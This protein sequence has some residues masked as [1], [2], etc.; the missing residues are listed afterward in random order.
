MKTCI[1]TILLLSFIS[2]HTLAQSS[3]AKNIDSILTVGKRHIESQQYREAAVLYLN[4]SQ[5]L[6]LNEVEHIEDLCLNGIDAMKFIDDQYLTRML[7]LRLAES[8]LYATQ[9]SKVLELEKKILSLDIELLT[10]DFYGAAAYYQKELLTQHGKDKRA[11]ELEEEH[12][13]ITNE[14]QEIKTAAPT[15]GLPQGVFKYDRYTRDNKKLSSTITI[16]GSTIIKES[17]LDELDI[18]YNS[19]PNF[20]YKVQSSV[21]ISDNNY[22]LCVTSL[23]YSGDESWYFLILQE[24]NDGLVISNQINFEFDY[25]EIDEENHVQQMYTILKPEYEN[26]LSEHINARSEIHYPD[27]RYDSLINLPVIPLDKVSEIK[28]EFLNKLDQRDDLNS[29]L[30]EDA[31]TEDNWFHYFLIDYYQIYAQ[32]DLEKIIFQKLLIEKGYEPFKS[33]PILLSLIHI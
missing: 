10:R 11:R 23:D 18:E 21:P 28:L 25:S 30:S 33:I 12:Q 32:D 19:T 7:H 24:L 31:Q 2:S 6:S 26:L 9:E 22:L 29:Y 8:Y 13:R 4:T 15:V 17:N 20:N 1:L 27:K 14:I 16:D 3:T 5:K